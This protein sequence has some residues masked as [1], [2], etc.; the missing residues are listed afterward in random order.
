MRRIKQIFNDNPIGWPLIVLVLYLFLLSYNQQQSAT[1]MRHNT[2]DL[3]PLVR[4][5]QVC[6]ASIPFNQRLVAP[7]WQD[8]LEQQL[9][10]NFPLHTN[11]LPDKGEIAIYVL[12]PS[13]S[14]KQ[15]QLD[16]IVFTP[17]L[18]T[19]FHTDYKIVIHFTPNIY[20]P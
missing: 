4:A 19:F 9:P 18:D 20:F 13:Y 3:R 14:Q 15:A 16:K 5:V 2:N 17:A 6:T 8:C 1:T 10:E 11:I 7:V 12:P